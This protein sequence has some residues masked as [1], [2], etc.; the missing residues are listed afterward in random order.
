MLCH[1]HF[2]DFFFIQLG[3]RDTLHYQWQS[4][5]FFPYVFTWFSI[6]YHYLCQCQI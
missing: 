3:L 4:T 2:A 5:I 1:N 6:I